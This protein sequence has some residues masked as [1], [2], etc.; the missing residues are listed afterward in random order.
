MRGLISF[1]CSVL[2]S[3]LLAGCNG[4]SPVPNAPSTQI[5]QAQQRI[6][7]VVVIYEENWS[8]DGLYGNYP[9]AN[10]SGGAT[11]VQQL[12]CPVG[13]ASDT[14]ALSGAPPALIVA[15]NPTG[16]WPCGWQGL[17]GGATDTNVPVGST[18][19]PFSIDTYDPPT[20]K[21]GDLWHV[22][23]HEQ[24]QIDNGALEPSNG[25]MD[26]FIEYSSNPG[27]AFSYYNGTILPEGKIAQHYTMADETFHSAFGGSFLNHQWLICACTPVWNQALPTSNVKT[28]ESYW[29]PTTKTLNDGKLTTMPTPQTAPGPQTGASYYDV[30]TTYSQNLPAPGTSPDQ[31]LVPIS[32]STKTIGDLMT[33]GFPPVSWK[34]YSGG[35]AQALANP[36]AANQCAYA[37]A[38][39]P[40]NNVPD[41]GPCFQWHHQP[42][43]YYRRWGGTG[44]SALAT[45][46]YLQ[47]DSKFYSDLAAGTLPQV[48]FIKPVGIDNEHPSYSALA[49]GQANV[50]KYLQALC[51]SN[52]WKNT[53]VF[54]TYDEN[55]G[56]WDHMTPPKIDQWG[57]GTRV[58]MIIISPY[59]KAGFVDHTQYETVSILSFIEKLFTLPSLGSR[60][61]KAVPPLNAFNFQ[62]APLACQSS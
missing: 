61:A 45:S 62:Q 21:T 1:W 24:L 3:A 14:V 30:N 54:I 36:T 18:I 42:F 15:G 2:A 51:S 4:N 32:P 46:P 23:W 58:P 10:G 35:F 9:G 22:F 43:V 38:A 6:A 33:D 16:P 48:S 37:S 60:D 50:Q 57:P 12:Q 47:D 13:G 11:S 41:N 27:M 20:T 8:F 56:R 17:S 26:K 7:H 55:G 25:S 53:A 31:L 49:E 52:Y 39:N 44:G 5:S 28:F 59:A 40:T 34:W 29:D 19:A